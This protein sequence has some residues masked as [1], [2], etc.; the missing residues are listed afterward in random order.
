[1]LAQD[2]IPTDIR[3]LSTA[4]LAAKFMQWLLV[5]NLLETTATFATDGPLYL[6][7][8]AL[9][10]GLTAYWIM[11]ADENSDVETAKARRAAID[12]EARGVTNFGLWT[13]LKG[14]TSR[15]LR[16][17]ARFGIPLG[18]QPRALML[19]YMTRPSQWSGIITLVANLGL[20]QL[21][22]KSWA[23]LS[24]VKDD[25]RH[26]GIVWVA[27]FLTSIA[28]IP[29]ALW[30]KSATEL[31]ALYASPLTVFLA[32]MVAL[33]LGFIG[34][35]RLLRLVRQFMDKW[36]IQG[37]T[38]SSTY[39][40]T[41]FTLLRDGFIDMIVGGA[42][43]LRGVG[44]EF[45]ATVAEPPVPLV[46]RDEERLASVVAASPLFASGLALDGPSTLITLPPRPS[47]QE[48]LR[49]KRGDK[50]WLSPVVVSVT[51]SPRRPLS[52]RRDV[53][54]RTYLA[55]RVRR[56]DQVPHAGSGSPLKPLPWEAGAPL[57]PTAT[58]Q[59]P[60]LPVAEQGR[61][62]DIVRRYA[63]QDEEPIV[64]LDE[65]LA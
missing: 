48:R 12:E 54:V 45:L 64:V 40:N 27:E 51:S 11:V 46:I 59:W 21:L 38:Y 41:L 61:T 25:W 23:D 24:K 19:E 56:P 9:F 14:F 42:D 47:R 52:L 13:Y 30:P 57:P 62:A 32:L 16:F 36:F 50:E 49:E 43:Q 17:V 58:S 37:W 65:W 53:L 34:P 33:A 22:G 2:F 4:L 35:R 8:G 29:A 55:N 7:T 31:L 20:Q 3:M 5:E 6:M 18:M 60:V 10:G 44:N 63:S 26:Q 39:F 1:V 15:M 28:S